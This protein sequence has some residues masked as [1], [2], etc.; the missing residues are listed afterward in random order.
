MSKRLVGADVG[1]PGDVQSVSGAVRA[2]GAAAEARARSIA[3]DAIRGCA[4]LTCR[5]QTIAEVVAE[6]RANGGSGD[7][8]RQEVLKAAGSIVR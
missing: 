6:C 5:V 2:A 3:V 1:L 7:T 4:Q 8:G